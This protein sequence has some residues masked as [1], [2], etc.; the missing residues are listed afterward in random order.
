MSSFTVLQEMGIEDVSSLEPV[1]APIWPEL[2]S[3]D[4]LI[5]RA[6]SWPRNSLNQTGSTDSAARDDSELTW[7]VYL[8]CLRGQ[9][10]SI[11]AQLTRAIVAVE[12]MIPKDDSPESPGES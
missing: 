12:S 5:R 3:Q 10:L 6:S 11:Q 8:G 7:V 2:Q 1:T 9:L 4:L